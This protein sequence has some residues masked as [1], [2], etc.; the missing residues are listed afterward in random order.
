M[1]LKSIK[2]D[3]DIHKKIKIYCTT[4]DINI[5][6]FVENTLNEKINQITNDINRKT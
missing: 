6:K 3:K 2:I 5:Y 4:N 1:E